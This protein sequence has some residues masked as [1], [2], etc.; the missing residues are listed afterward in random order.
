M[1]YE[2]CFWFLHTF[3]QKS[4]FEE[5]HRK[6]FDKIVAKNQDTLNTTACK[7]VFDSMDGIEKLK[8][9]TMYLWFVFIMK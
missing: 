4:F 8:T 2:S 3:L 7:A 9:T 5:K 6:F 1:C